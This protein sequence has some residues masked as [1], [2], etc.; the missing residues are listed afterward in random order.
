M[1]ITC[2][3]KNTA[4]YKQINAKY[5]DDMTTTMLILAWQQMN[6][7][8]DIPTLSVMENDFKDAEAVFD[9]ESKGFSKDVVNNLVALDLVKRDGNNY[10][11]VGD[12]IEKIKAYLAF[13]N[14]DPDAA[15]FDNGKFFLNKAFYN[16]TTVSKKSRN[17]KEATHI[18][19][20]VEHMNRIFP[21]VEIKMVSE[22][23]G[24]KY[25]DSLPD[26]AKANVKFSEMNS[27]YID[28]KAYLIEERVTDDMLVEEV[29]HPFIDAIKIP[30]PQV[31]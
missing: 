24:K 28:G 18:K 16:L 30:R 23:E 13:Q 7:S 31:I 20:L 27:F 19:P 5:K 29:L 17:N 11:V 4:E 26:S 9:V 3:N 2:P 14:I 22:A 25:Y 15:I 12:S 21:G 1:G 6:N 10:V 8:S